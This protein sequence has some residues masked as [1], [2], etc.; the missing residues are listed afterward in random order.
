MDVT[1][2]AVLAVI[3][4]MLVIAVLSVCLR[5]VARRWSRLPVSWSDW[6]ILLAL[7]YMVVYAGALINCRLSSV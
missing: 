6:L 7:L 3:I 4:V 1:G 2:E 5:F